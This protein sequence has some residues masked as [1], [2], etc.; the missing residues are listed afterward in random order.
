DGKSLAFLQYTSGSTGQ[1]KGAMLTHAN[2]MANLARI[3]TGFGTSRRDVLV[4]WLPLYH[5]MGLIGGVLQPVYAAIETTLFAPA[6]F[7][8]RP[9]SWLQ[10]ISDTGASVSGGPNFAY[11]LCLHRIA[12]DQLDGLDLSRWEVAFNGAEPIRVATLERF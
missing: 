1:P 4:S 7:L 10:T 5:D 11:E 2:L 6:Q 3:A 9:L 8:Q 12:D